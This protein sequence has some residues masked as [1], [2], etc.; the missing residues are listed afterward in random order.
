MYKSIYTFPKWHFAMIRVFVLWQIVFPSSYCFLLRSAPP[1]PPP[2][3]HH[4]ALIMVV[5]TLTA[6]LFLFLC[7][8]SVCGSGSVYIQGARWPADGVLRCRTVFLT[9]PSETPCPHLDT[10]CSYWTPELNGYSLLSVFICCCVCETKMPGL[11]WHLRFWRES[12]P[13]Y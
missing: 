6:L 8:L 1:P 9:N 3:Y 10:R 7:C 13:K 5:I 2:H 4:L 11:S 12:A